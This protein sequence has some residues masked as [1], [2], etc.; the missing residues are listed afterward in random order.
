LKVNGL[1]AGKYALKVDGIELPPVDAGALDAGLNLAAI[2]NLPSN[3]QANE[4]LA[5]TYK[6]N[7]LHFRRWRQVQFPVSKN[8]E[9]P[10]ANV[11]EQMADLDKQDADAAEAQHMAAQPKPHTVELYPIL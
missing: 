6:H 9:E 7:D 5:Q 3:E 10:P 11:K 2:P 8:G 4:V 1:P